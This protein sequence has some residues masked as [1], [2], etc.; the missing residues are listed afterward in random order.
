M[1]KSSAPRGNFGDDR[2]LWLGRLPDW[3]GLQ[4]KVS[5]QRSMDGFHF[6]RALDPSAD[7]DLTAGQE[8][9]VR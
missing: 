5:A 2:F 8:G 1:K 3:R 6:S 4:V 7:L 9:R